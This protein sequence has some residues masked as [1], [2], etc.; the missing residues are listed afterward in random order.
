MQII[1]ATFED[2]V[3]RPAQPLNLPAHAE[4]RI[5][6]ELLSESRLSVGSLTAFLQSLPALG[7]D[8]EQFA[9]DVRSIRA[10]FSAE[11]NSQD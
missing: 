4:V 5:T 6:S 9:Q 3:L 10:E 8:T 11:A 2:G 7:D 1:T